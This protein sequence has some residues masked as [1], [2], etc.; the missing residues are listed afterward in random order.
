VDRIVLGRIPFEVDE[1][2]L[3]ALLRIKPGTRN[4]GDLSA[5]LGEA[6]SVAAPKA[7][8]A[9]AEA[10]AADE[11]ALEIGGVRFTSRLL[12][13]NLE[14]AG[15]V[16]PFAATCG[17]ELEEWSKTVTGTL[18]SF[19]ADTIML[20]ALG[21]AVAFLD[22]HLKE[23]LGPDALPSTMNP[24]SL[25]DWPLEEQAPLFSLLGTCARDIGVRLTDHMVLSPLKS[26]SGIQ[27]VSDHEFVN[28]S[29]CPRQGC[30]SRRAE[31]DPALYRTAIGNIS[32]P[33]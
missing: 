32:P 4:E 25:E 9:V 31:Y 33:R 7:A 19:W 23:R 6:R 12:R 27:F 8:F 14:K 2:G 24:G 22:N 16:F 20:M 10:R 1:L 3:A 28:C 29:L 18:R 11:G 30:A 15:V 17:I 26:V 13:T 5:I 21:C